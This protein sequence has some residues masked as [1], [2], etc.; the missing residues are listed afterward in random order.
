MISSSLDNIAE[1]TLV[2]VDPTSG[3]WSDQNLTIK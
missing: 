2:N 3:S 1:L